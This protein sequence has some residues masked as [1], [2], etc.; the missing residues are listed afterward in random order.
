MSKLLTILLALMFS[1]GALPSPTAAAP[2]TPKGT[3]ATDWTETMAGRKGQVARSVHSGKQRVTYTSLMH[4]PGQ[5]FNAVGPHWKAEHPEGS[6]IEVSVRTS[7]DGKK[8]NSWRVVEENHG[9]D[10]R[11]KNAREFGSLVVGELARYAQY[12]VVT[13]PSPRG[14]WPRVSDVTLTYID[15]TAG[16]TAAEA[17]AAAQGSYQTFGVSKPEVIS[18]A[19]WGADESYRFDSSGKEVWGREYLQVTKAVLHDTI[20]ANNDP[21]PARTVRSIYYYHAVT[22]GWGDIGYNYLIDEQGRIYEGRFG[23]ENVVA[24]HALCYNFGTLGV[25]ALGDH[26][27]VAP[28]DAMVGAFKKIIA[29]QFDRAGIDPLGHSVFMT[30]DVE[31]K[32][33]LPNILAHKDTSYSSVPCSNTHVDPGTYLYNRFDE[34][35]KGVAALMGYTPVARPGITDVTF[36]PTT[37]DRG[38]TLRVE[39]TIENTGTGLMETQAPYPATVYAESE[40][41]GDRGFAKVTGKYRVYAD[42][43]GNPTG[44]PGP[45]RWGLGSPLLPGQARVV[46]GYVNLPTTGTATWWIGLNNEG[47]SAVVTKA[48]A[49]SVSVVSSGASD[50]TGGVIRSAAATPS[51]ISP[52]GDGTHDSTN[53]S[54]QL[55]SAQK[56]KMELYTAD[57]KWVKT[58]RPWTA[59]T[60]DPQ[61]VSMSGAYYDQVR[62]ETFGL[63]E[64]QYNVLIVSRDS[65]GVVREAT[66]PVRVDLTHPTASVGRSP[67][68][69]SPNGDGV[70]DSSRVSGSFSEAAG[71]TLSIHNSAGSLVRRYSGSGTS[72]SRYWDGKNGSGQV[73]PD[74]SYTYNLA[75]SDTAGNPG[76]TKSG[77]ILVDNVRPQVSSLTASGSGP[78][79]LSYKLSERSRVAVVITNAAGDKVAGIAGSMKNAGGNSASWDG[80]R[81]DGSA[82]PAGTYYWKLYVVDLAGNRATAYPASRSFSVSAPGQQVVDNS[83][84]GFTASSNWGSGSYNSPYGVDYRYRKA[85]GSAGDPATFTAA[86][87]AGTYDVYAWYTSG[88]N[89]TTTAMYGIAHSGGTKVVTVNQQAGG[90]EWR[91]LGAFSFNTGSYK[92][93]LGA[94]AG[95]SGVVIADAIRWVKR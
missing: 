32:A 43:G 64:A 68:Y 83:G 12:K 74:G 58:I 89:R 28:S 85:D 79:N 35:R 59:V 27:K 25:A 8:W 1:A 31:P 23:G 38:R 47:V 75:Y 90:G 19:Q 52:N 7:P 46:T 22:R 69:I 78:Y 65:G 33:D 9:D 34:I 88:T 26:S 51:S 40:D 4:S 45:Y 48:G 56:A 82:A 20:T 36:A 62:R 91:L 80:L 86:L 44:T 92:V 10:N 94:P 21:D 24:G 42:R 61:K 49:A 3:I 18:R 81:S 11:D 30:R 63:P 71:W 67:A 15:A 66:V 39:V 5:Q 14:E 72:F 6:S 13:G 70:Q 84:G 16:P 93:A 53:I 29:W 50:T 2:L 76:A 41:F 77:S 17:Q 57:G 37:L 73:M 87:G 95:S 55:S 60:T 54:Y